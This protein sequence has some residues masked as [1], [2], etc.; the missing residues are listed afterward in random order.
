MKNDDQ[1]TNTILKDH[2]DL[3]FNN[4]LV[5]N[6][7][8]SKW[9]KFIIQHIPQRIHKQWIFKGYFSP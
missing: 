4:F 8:Q 7:A 9:R 3:K 5:G 6:N 1:K 2:E